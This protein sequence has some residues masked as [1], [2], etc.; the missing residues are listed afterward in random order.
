MGGGKGKERKNK[1]GLDA[2]CSR[3]RGKTKQAEPFDC[4]RLS[5]L[6]ANPH[7]QA[8]RRQILSDRNSDNGENMQHSN[9]YR[10]PRKKSPSGTCKVGRGR[11][12]TTVFTGELG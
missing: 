10:G 2:I 1:A 8:N 5:G 6:L 3:L 9:P 4:N 12:D 11:K 7:Q